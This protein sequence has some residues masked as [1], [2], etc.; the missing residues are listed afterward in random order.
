MK[1]ETELQIM[2]QCEKCHLEK[3]RNN[4]VYP[5]GNF[6]A[7]I[8]FQGE[9]PGREEDKKGI[10][11]VGRTS[12]WFA[13]VLKHLGLEES[14]VYITNSVKCRTA[15]KEDNNRK[16][17]KKEL[18]VCAN[19][20]IKKELSHVNPNIIVLMGQTALDTY[21]TNCKIGVTAGEEL[22]GHPLS[23]KFDVKFFSIYHPS[24]L[25][26]HPNKYKPIFT[27]HLDS[28]K[29]KLEIWR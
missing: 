6:N 8:L 12:K 10:P 29:E 16:P 20:W 3:T 5:R 24:V 4:V 9:A 19:T 13:A 14:D 1:P 26:Y 22:K 21:F 23:L 7:D 27:E 18:E 11:F 2:R 28:L 25:L 15:D 17:T